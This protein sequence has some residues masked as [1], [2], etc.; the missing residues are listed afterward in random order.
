MLFLF[1]VH[2]KDIKATVKNLIVLLTIRF[3]DILIKN[4]QR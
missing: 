1:Q 2:F 4:K 3:I